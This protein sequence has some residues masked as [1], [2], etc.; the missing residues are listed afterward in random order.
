MWP[1][2]NFRMK[3]LRLPLTIRNIQVPNSFSYSTVSPYTRAP[4][5]HSDY[6]TLQLTLHH[7]RLQYMR[8]IIRTTVLPEKLPHRHGEQ[9]NAFI[10]ISELRKVKNVKLSLCAPGRHIGSGGTARR[11]IHL[12]TDLGEWSA[13]RFPQLHRRRKSSFYPLHRRKGET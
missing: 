3:R 1:K 9:P 7:K 13:S 2:C 5:C 4:T 10:G 12:R 8:Q 6:F 11:V